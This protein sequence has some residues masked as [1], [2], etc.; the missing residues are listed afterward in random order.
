MSSFPLW[1]VSP[2]QSQR[3]TG[4]RIVL[5][6]TAGFFFL[7]S[8]FV[9]VAT[10][11]NLMISFGYP[12][13]AFVRYGFYLAS[14]ALP[15]G[16]IAVIAALP[17]CFAAR[18][19]GYIGLAP[20]LILALAI[21]LLLSSALWVARMVSFELQAFAL[22]LVISQIYGLALWLILRVVCVTGFRPRAMAGR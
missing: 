16:L 22:L 1:Q 5:G 10:L 7:P 3:I 6:V 17:F 15:Y 21:C 11:M 20:A 2:I 19:T 18:K 14:Q 9:V 8:F 4:A 13:P 12:V